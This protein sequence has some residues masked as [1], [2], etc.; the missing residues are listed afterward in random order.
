MTE[1]TSGW[2]DVVGQP[3]AVRQLR[4]AA[5]RGPV[6]AYLFVGPS[7]STKLQAARAFA[8]QVI[9]GGDDADQRDA[10]L[11]LAGMHPD[12][13]EIRR[14]GAAISAEQAREIVRI[15]SLAPTEGDRK[16]LILDEF[17]LLRPEGAALLLKTIEEPPP[18][19]LFVIL[20]DFVPSDLITISSRCVRIDFRS[21]DTDLVTERLVAEGVDPTAAA[22]A[23]AAAPGDLDR[24]RVLANDPQLAARRAAFAH[25]PHQLD[26]T[27]AVAIRT[28]AELL[29]MIDAAAEP[30]TERHEQE[31]V[32]LDEQIARYGEKGNGRKQLDERH[33]RELRRYRTDELRAGLATLAA[34][35]RDSLTVPGSTADVTQCARAVAMIHDALESL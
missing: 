24:A 18:S 33:K 15:S 21:I 30:L 5:A 31:I 1:H 12:V 27:G 4:D 13:R 26:G 3:T 34:A 20:A 25:A 9:S 28:A 8:A 29:A 14:T 7:G 17:H 35:Y 23:A 19:T 2:R 16:V 11:V 6:H 22:T 32:A 10:R